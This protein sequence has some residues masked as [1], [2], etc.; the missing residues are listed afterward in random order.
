MRSEAW[1]AGKEGKPTVGCAQAGST[2]PPGVD[3]PHLGTGSQDV[4]KALGPPV[5]SCL[6]DSSWDQV[7][8]LAQRRAEG[9]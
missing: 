1:E 9:T 2:R 6:N 5:G 7:R 4:R 3:P 8:E